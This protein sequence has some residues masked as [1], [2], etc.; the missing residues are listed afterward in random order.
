[1]PFFILPD[2]RGG[3]GDGGGLQPSYVSNDKALDTAFAAL[4][5]CGQC[6]S[7]R[8]LGGK[9][10]LCGREPGGMPDYSVATW[11]PF[12]NCTLGEAGIPENP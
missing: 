6:V 9:M 3:L 5:F 7:I 4:K 8:R 2:L 10:D 12:V 11:P 1:M